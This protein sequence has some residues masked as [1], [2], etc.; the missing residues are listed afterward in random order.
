M[1][2]V[3]LTGIGVITTNG[4][5]KGRDFFP[6]E[7]TKENLLDLSRQ[8]LGKSDR[9]GRMDVYSRLGT[10]AA[11]LALQD[12]GLYEHEEKR[13]IGIIAS[14]FSGSLATDREFFK[15][16]TFENG[17]LASPK[18][19]VY[20]LSSSFLGEACLR[21]GLTGGSFIVNEQKLDG[22]EG[23]RTAVENIIWGDNE[24]MLAGFCELFTRLCVQKS[25]GQTI[26]ADTLRAEPEAFFCVLEK[27]LR[28]DVRPYGTVQYDQ[29]R[30]IY[31]QGQS[32]NTQEEFLCL[33]LQKEVV[34]I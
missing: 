23:V 2:E 5:W 11:A 29:K 3:F 15:T 17:L 19:F 32:V 24:I 25:I 14:T 10:L 7:L 27:S 34:F 1:K 9:I 20:T 22:L 26:D 30:T 4:W 28:D 13:P 21:F 33:C 31:F 12:A 8:I 18:L 16:V 6:L